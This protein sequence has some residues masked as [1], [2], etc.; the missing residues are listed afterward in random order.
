[1]RGQAAGDEPAHL[2]ALRV[3]PVR[4]V[5]DH[6]QGYVSG[7]QRQQIE[8]GDAQGH[9][10]GRLA[11]RTPEHGV[12]G[13]PGDPVEAG[14]PREQRVQ[15]LVQARERQLRLGLH[16]GRADDA[17]SERGG[18]RGGGVQQDALA[19][20]RLAAQQQGPAVGRRGQPGELG[21]L[22]LPAH[23][24]PLVRHAPTPPPSSPDTAAGHGS[25]GSGAVSV[26]G[27]HAAPD[28]SA[29]SVH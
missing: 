25:S 21:E 29:C 3:E 10:G 2:G 15:Q 1:M 19:D 6:Q 16:S 7:G 26:P 20:A 17:V 18:V 4:V 5:D 12:E 9:H 8:Y 11:R 22:R 14:G 24:R 13:G 28:A 27:D 23:D